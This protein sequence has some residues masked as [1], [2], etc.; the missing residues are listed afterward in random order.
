M[1][2]TLSFPATDKSTEQGGNHIFHYGVSEM[3]GWRYSMEDVH[4]VVLNLDEGRSES[5]AFFAVYDGHG[6]GGASKYAGEHVHKRLIDTEA[7]QR[8]DYRAALKT[9]FLK[10]DEDMRTDPTFKRDGSGCTAVAALATT[11][12]RVYVANAGDSRSVLSVK[13]GAE[14]LSFDHKP[15][16]EPEKNRITAAG[17]YVSYGRVNG[18]LALARALGD[19]DYKKNDS[20]SAEAQIITGDPEIIEHDVTEEDEFFIV[21][22]DGIWD[23][24]TSQQAVNVV[25]IL[26]SQGKQL[27]EI[28]EEICDLCMAPDTQGGNGIGCDNMTLMIVAI[29]HGRT[30]QEWADWITDRVK[31]NYGYPTPHEVPQLYSQSRI[32][33]FKARKA[34]H[35]ELMRR[36]RESGNKANMDDFDEVEAGA[37]FRALA[38]RVL[39]GTGGMTF[40]SIN[41]AEPLMFDNENEDDEDSYV[42][43]PTGPSLHAEDNEF[44]SVIFGKRDETKSLKEQLDEL[45]MDGDLDGDRDVSSD[46]THSS[47]SKL[48]GEAPPSP[49]PTTNGDA[50]PK[51]S[52]P[53]PQGDAPSGAVKAEGLLDTSESPFNV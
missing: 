38:H 45:E 36:R 14:Q 3:Q 43:T 44:T 34:S 41:N 9:A 27:T 39:G 18:N 5:N 26:V 4:T 23:C 1:G 42:E 31:E 48:Q 12:G 50:H 52:S 29:L 20:L 15:T 32:N 33:S 7:Y 49:A 17:G 35:D 10:T 25:R 22:C 30:V 11:D 28:C 6:G 47:S 21:A 8:G 51:E 24:L 13:G 40:N 37:A 53:K 16:N 2:Q 46:D 19:F